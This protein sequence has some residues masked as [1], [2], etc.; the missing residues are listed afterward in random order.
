MTLWPYPLI[1]IPYPNPLTKFDGKPGWISHIE[2]NGVCMCVCVCNYVSIDLLPLY[3]R[4]SVVQS[5]L[6]HGRTGIIPYSAYISR[7]A[8]LE[9]FVEIIS[10]MVPNS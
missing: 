10:R 8:V 9:N 2:S 7:I 1:P 3:T 5:V 6:G 4:N